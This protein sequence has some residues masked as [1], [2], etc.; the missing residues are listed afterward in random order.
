MFIQMLGYDI[1]DPVEVMPEFTADIGTKKGE[2]VD[3]ALMQDGAPVV[4]VECKK[5]GTILSGEAVS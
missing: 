4:L 1:F 5:L 2:K 3:Y